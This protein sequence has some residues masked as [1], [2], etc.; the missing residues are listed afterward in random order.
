MLVTLAAYKVLCTSP[1][2]LWRQSSTNLF[3]TSCVVM[4]VGVL[5]GLKMVSLIIKQGNF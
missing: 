2:L 1:I 4:F 5:G 3:A